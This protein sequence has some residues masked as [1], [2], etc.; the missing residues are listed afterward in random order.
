MKSKGRLPLDIDNDNL[1]QSIVV[2]E[3]SQSDEELKEVEKMAQKL[4]K[5]V[6]QKYR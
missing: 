6:E 2:E 5:N 1:K 3:L 4:H